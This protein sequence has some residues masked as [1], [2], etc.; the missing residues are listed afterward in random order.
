M[1]CKTKMISQFDYAEHRMKPILLAGFN[2]LSF[3]W[4]YGEDKS[5][6]PDCKACG[7]FLPSLQAGRLAAQIPAAMAAYINISSHKG[8][9]PKSREAKGRGAVNSNIQ[10]DQVSGSQIIPAKVAGRPQS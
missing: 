8:K 9:V 7:A 4:A 5:S 2:R 10:T 1:H 6:R 3:R